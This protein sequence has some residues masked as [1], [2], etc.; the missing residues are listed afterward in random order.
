MNAVAFSFELFGLMLGLLLF[1][2]FF[3]MSEMAFSAVNKVRLKTLVDQNVGGS[4]KALWISENFD[5]ALT[6]LLVGNNLANIGLTTVSVYFFSG[7]F[8][9]FENMNVI[10]AWVNS[11]GVTI[12]VLIFGEI[13]PKTLAKSDPEKI[14]LRISG[15][16]YFLIKVMTPITFLFR[17]LN[18]RV[19]KNIETDGKLTVTEDELETIID[20]MEEEGSIDEEEATMLQKV[21]DLSDITVAEIM[22]PRVDMVAIDIQ[23]TVDQITEM[24]FKHKF[25]RIPVYDGSSDNIIGI[26]Y[27]RDFFTKLI[28]GQQVSVKKLLKKPLFVPNSTKVDALIELLQ[29]ENNHMAIVVDEYGG[30]DGLVTMEDALE[31]LVGEIYDEHDDVDAFVLK[32]DDNQYI[33]NADYDLYRLFED[34]KLGEPPVSDSISVGGWLFE[35][36]Q[37][38]PEVGDTHEHKLTVN[39]VFDELSQLVS[40]DIATLTFEVLKVKKRRIQVVKVTLE[41]EPEK[42]DYE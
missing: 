27:E 18:S 35:Q 41:I 32:H 9:S 8:Q 11:I 36:F 19:V 20:T 37:E 26:L 14:A 28:K 33:V 40:E 39:Q 25:S 12:V 16:V 24:F 21:L 15:I 13:L 31:E 10:V 4:H 17:K 34:L 3:S 5:R 7:L 30:V 2:F 42:R 38:I 22:T 29:L 6:T 1:S 23:R